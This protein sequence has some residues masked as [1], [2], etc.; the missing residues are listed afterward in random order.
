[1]HKYR[2]DPAVKTWTHRLAIRIINICFAV[3]YHLNGIVVQIVEIVRCMRD[4]VTANVKHRKV[5]EDGL[6]ELALAELIVPRVNRD[7]SYHGTARTFS[8]LG[9]VSSKR[10]ISLP[11]YISAKYWFKIAAFKWP[12]CK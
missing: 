6:L 2:Q 3:L 7:D 4:F 9:L 12:I 1:M 10:M 8:L 5:F 11:L